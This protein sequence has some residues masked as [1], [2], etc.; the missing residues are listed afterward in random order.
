V[1]L[2]PVFNEEDTSQM[3]VISSSYD[4]AHLREPENSA[5]CSAAEFIFD[6]S[7]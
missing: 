5:D 6:V 7:K 2:Q 3:V 4:F 1:T